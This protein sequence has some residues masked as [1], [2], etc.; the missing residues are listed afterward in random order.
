[1]SVGLVFFSVFFAKLVLV[2]LLGAYRRKSGWL[3]GHTKFAT[4]ML[5][6]QFVPYLL[7]SASVSFGYSPS[8]QET[9]T[10]INSSCSQEGI[11]LDLDKNG[12]QRETASLYN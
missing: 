2:G 5:E 7:P 10:K 11:S 8:L 6:R 12:K 4:P 3:V 9:D 1:M